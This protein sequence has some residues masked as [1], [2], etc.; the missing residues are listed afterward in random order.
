MCVRKLSVS[1]V[2]LF[3]MVGVPAFAAVFGA[4]SGNVRDPQDRPIEGAEVTLRA[5]SSAWNTKTTT[6]VSGA[7]RFVVVPLGDYSVTVTDPGFA[8][9][10]VGVTV[11]SGEAIPGFMGAMMMPYP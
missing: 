9:S 7:F 6:D 8:P 10:T 11:I 4:V 2:G 5:K 1:L 3:V